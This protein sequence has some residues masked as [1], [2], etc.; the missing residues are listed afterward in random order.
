MCHFINLWNVVYER[1]SYKSL[2]KGTRALLQIMLRKYGM[3]ITYYNAK[4]GSRKITQYDFLLWCYLKPRV[5]KGNYQFLLA[6]K[7]I[8]LQHVA[9]I[10][11]DALLYTASGIISRLCILDVTMDTLAVVNHAEKIL[12]FWQ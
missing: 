9:A 3:H 2:Q 4:F 5:Y 10:P 8:T 7:N 11:I 1:S 12:I 6:L